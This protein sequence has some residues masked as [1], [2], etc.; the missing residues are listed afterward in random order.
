M[1]LTPIEV[2]PGF[3]RAY[4][5]KPEAMCHAIKSTVKQLRTDW[6]HPGLHAH[7]MQGAVGVWE[8]YVDRANRVTF[9][10][11]DD[12]I[13]LLNHCNHDVLRKP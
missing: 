6:R 4:K 9:R 10:W 11:D 1:S 5:R 2:S 12:T 8:A 3:R 13:V 7:K